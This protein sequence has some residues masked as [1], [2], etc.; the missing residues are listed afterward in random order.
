MKTKL[1]KVRMER[2]GRRCGLLNDI[3]VSTD[4]SR[5][6]LYLAWKGDVTINLEVIL[7]RILTSRFWK[8][9]WETVES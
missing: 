2:V 5:G 6:G 8:V 7:V 4:G 9:M 3:D 1:N